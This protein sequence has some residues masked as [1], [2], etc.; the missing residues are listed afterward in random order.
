[1]LV[2]IYGELSKKERRRLEGHL[3]RCASCRGE[4][5]ET[6]KVLSS[7]EAAPAEPSPRVDWER[8]WKAIESGLEPNLRRPRF[9]SAFPRWAF[10]PLALAVLFILGIAVGR[11]WWPWRPATPVTAKLRTLSPATEQALLS[12]YFED[13]RPVLMDYAHNG[14]RPDNKGSLLTDREIARSLLVQN[15]LLKRA[16]ARKNPNLADLFDDLGM[17]LTE[18]ANLQGQDTAT[19][20]AL[21][22]VIRQRQVLS[23]IRRLEKI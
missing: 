3:N 19:P 17:I 6:R 18:I 8:N 10:A 4:F 1:M 11:Y 13:V 7:L 23:R 20:A 16:L 9:P 2:D 12:Q 21:K 14:A 5:E 15:L 22:D